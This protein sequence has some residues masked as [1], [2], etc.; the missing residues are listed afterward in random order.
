MA[1]VKDRTKNGFEYEYDN[2]V[3]ADWEVMNWFTEILELQEIPE[4]TRSSE[5]NMTL[6]RDMYAV[7]RKVFT[8]SQVAA[9]TNSNRNEKGEVVS[10]WMWEDFA[11][12]FL[13]DEHKDKTTKNS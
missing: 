11:D 3:F 8:R 13:G 9:W 7:I 1:I 10:E 6:L 12:I 5:D 4:E 2:D